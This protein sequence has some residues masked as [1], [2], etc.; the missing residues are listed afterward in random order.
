MFEKTYAQQQARF[1]YEQKK[2]QLEQ[3]KEDERIIMIYTSGMPKMLAGFLYSTSNGYCSKK[4]QKAIKFTLFFSQTLF[5]Y[6]LSVPYICHMCSIRSCCC[7]LK[8]ISSKLL[9]S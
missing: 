4:I 8:K 5:V 2:L 1:T 6:K 9:D 3:M 7:I